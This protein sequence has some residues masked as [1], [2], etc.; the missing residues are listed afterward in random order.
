MTTPFFWQQLSRNVLGIFVR[1]PILRKP[2]A[3]IIIG[4]LIGLIGTADY[5]SGIEVSLAVFYLLPIML[6]TGW[7][8]PVAGVVL[9]VISSVIRVASDWLIVFPAFLPAHTV[10]NVLATLAISLFVVWLLH[11]F[12]TLHR[13]LEEKVEERT[14]DLR[15]SLVAL[16]RLQHELLEVSARERNAIGRELHDELGQH[17]VAT[18]MAAQVLARRLDGKS[19]PDAQAI[20]RWIEEAIAKSR[21]LARGLLLSA[22]QP[23]R[24]VQELEELAAAS[25]QGEVQCRVSYQGGPV[26]ADPGECAQLFRVVQ[27]AVSN[28]LRHAHAHHIT[29]TLATDDHALC[30][31]V[32]D[33]GCGMPIAAS[34]PT[35]MG[36]RIMEHRAKFV[37]ASFSWLSKP[38]EGTKVVCRLPRRVSTKA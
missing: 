12:I 15:E 33:D 14:Q 20:V 6:A 30:L 3:W 27:E 11:A 7:L 23:E 9:A 34:A 5:F 26:T 17:L 25:T 31:M 13:Q 35:G 29:I 16:E 1:P 10:W 32:E 21:K 38:E 2:T 18:A 22:I 8:G 24:F 37:G 19:A 28:A 4:G 36:L